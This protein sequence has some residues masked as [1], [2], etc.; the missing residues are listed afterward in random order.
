MPFD[1]EL[2]FLQKKFKHT[3]HDDD[4]DVDE[5]MSIGMGWF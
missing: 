3:P 4:D 1:S 5:M 2:Y